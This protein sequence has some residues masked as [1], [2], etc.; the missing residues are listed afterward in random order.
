LKRKELN[1]VEET[2]KKDEEKYNT[3]INKIENELLEEQYRVGAFGKSGS[4]N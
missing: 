3:K 1:E 4:N 2:I